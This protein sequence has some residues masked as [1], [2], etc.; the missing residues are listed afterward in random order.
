[1]DPRTLELFRC[2]QSGPFDASGLQQIRRLLDS[3][4]RLLRGS[5]DL[6][7]LAE[8]VQLLEG[9]ASSAG[10][11]STGAAA[12]IEAAEIAERELWQVSLAND[13]RA[14][15]AREEQASP[16][17][18]AR[19]ARREAELERVS[20]EIAR[21]ERALDV[22]AEP[23]AVQRLAE[24][25]VQRGAEGDRAQAADLYCTLGE[26]LGAPAGLPYLA[27][28]LAQVPSHAEAKA[29][30]ALYNA[31][32]SAAPS[33]GRTPRAAQRS[34]ARGVAYAD[35]LSAEAAALPSTERPT[36]PPKTSPVPTAL[37]GTA[38]SNAETVLRVPQAVLPAEQQPA[39]RART[40]PAGL[41]PSAAGFSAH[42]EVY[43][44]PSG[45][46]ELAPARVIASG[47]HEGGRHSP[48][49]ADSLAG[50]GAR[51]GGAWPHG[52]AADSPADARSRGAVSPGAYALGVGTRAGHAVETPG[53]GRARRS[54]TMHGLPTQRAHDAGVPQPTAA[55]IA[56]RGSD[57]DALAGE[58]RFG[59][60][61]SHERGRAERVLAR[62][63]GARLDDEVS[64]GSPRGLAVQHTAELF[65]AEASRESV[66]VEAGSLSRQELN[67]AESSRES[68]RVLPAPAVAGVIRESQA[69]QGATRSVA[70]SLRKTLVWNA[71]LTPDGAP[72]EPSDLPQ[73]GLVPSPP[74]AAHEQP[75]NT[76]LTPDNA[77]PALLPNLDR[78]ERWAA[79][80]DPNAV[81]GGA[82]PEHASPPRAVNVP[83]FERGS[84]S[85]APAIGSRHGAAMPLP[86]GAAEADV[87][88]AQLAEG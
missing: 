27:C 51:V 12:L 64:G 19:A 4:R 71:Q 50:M 24:L 86:L 1:M 23:A 85:D 8:L 16:G 20:R 35:P 42:S 54:P 28:A 57:A 77:W 79:A 21:M 29:L 40:T 69:Q 59:A 32:P 70:R 26:V 45:A 18:M 5:G 47:A 9:W 11:G 36:A 25:Y 49:Q 63:V 76:H 44:P 37:G 10:V 48:S 58:A 3:Q 87:L 68:V 62:N 80:N 43:E 61:P 52:A 56:W 74:S 75:W 60:E 66:R 31:D 38:R 17:G 6:A 30:L 14:R 39:V 67:G 81:V 22:N 83:A 55:G 46:A 2:L 7:T 73:S 13:L 72:P 65:G 53:I 34:P 84:R 33:P 15:A 82:A 78:G 41:Q 88:L